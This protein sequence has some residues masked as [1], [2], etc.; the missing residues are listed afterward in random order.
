MSRW[1]LLWGPHLF[2][3]SGVNPAGM[4]LCEWKETSMTIRLVGAVGAL[5]LVSG[6]SCVLADTTQINLGTRNNAPNWLVTG[7]GTVTSPA[8]QRGA[9]ITL[10]S[11]GHRDGTFLEGG[12]L[13][14]FNG[15]WYA[16]NVFSIPANA[17]DVSLTFSGLEGDDRVV[18]ELNA[19]PIGDFFIHGGFSQPPIT[20]GGVMS[21]PPGP[22]DI[23]YTFTGITSGTITGGFN[24]GGANDLR[25]I[26]NNTNNDELTAPTKTFQTSGDATDATLTATVTY[27]VVPEPATAAM[28]GV[29]A[30][31]ALRRRRASQ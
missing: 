15:F 31:A 23:D 18:L 9:E 29:G 24:M 17:T 4:V 11:D 19:V 14:D 30:L 13:A 26:I 21:F 28:F 7:A 25:L 3:S 22:P 20:G 6:A 10:T 1:H 2:G 12:S 5:L 27:T 16:D 8:I